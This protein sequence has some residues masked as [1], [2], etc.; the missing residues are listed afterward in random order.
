MSEKFYVIWFSLCCL[1]VLCYAQ[2]VS[3]HADIYIIYRANLVCTYAQQ[4]IFT[5]IQCPIKSKLVTKIDC[6]LENDSA[7]GIE[8]TT[9]NKDVFS[10]VGMA[11]INLHI[12]GRKN[13]MRLNGFRLEICKALVPTTRPSMVTFLY[14]GIQ[15]TKNNLH[16]CPFKRVWQLLNIQF[17]LNL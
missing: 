2:K 6:Y 11:N 14:S 3:L 13:I 5:Q 16:K 12:H 8:V 17:I 9:N 7:L 10:V 1:L 4:L 15:K